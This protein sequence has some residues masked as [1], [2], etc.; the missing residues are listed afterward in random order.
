MIPPKYFLHSQWD[1]MHGDTQNQEKDKVEKH[2]QGNGRADNLKTYIKM[3]NEG[4]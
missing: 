1:V 3:M 2:A 4:S